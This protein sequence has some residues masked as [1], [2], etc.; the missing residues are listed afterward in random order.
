[1]RIDVVVGS[2]YGDEGKGKVVN[3]LNEYFNYDYVFRVNASTNASH[4]VTNNENVYI[5]KQLPSIFFKK[6]TKLIVSPGA[7]LNLS[8]LKEE[9]FNRPDIEEIKDNI[10]IASSI[11]LII[12]PFIHKNKNCEY[13]KKIGST[14]QGTGVAMVTRV[15]RCDIKL[16]DVENAARDKSKIENLEEK[17]RIAC[18]NLKI[19][20][21][22]CSINKISIDLINDFIEI[23][24]K[25]GKF[26]YDYTQFLYDLI[27]KDKKQLQHILI[28]GCNG[29]L[30]DN[31]H[32]VY[33]Y[34]TSCSTSIS[35]LLN[36][37]NLSP[38]DL[39]NIF[40]VM[41]AYTCCLN[42]RPFVTEM[43]S[44]DASKIYNN[45]PEV[46]YAE[47]MKR[48]VGWLDLVVLKKALLGHI[49]CNLFINKLDVLQDFEELKICYAYK[50]KDGRIINILPDDISLIDG[51][52]PL[53]K[54]FKGFGKIKYSNNTPIKTKEINDYVNFILDELNNDN[55]S[56]DVYKLGFGP[57]S[58]NLI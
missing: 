56:C 25:V 42:K 26:C 31:L 53:Y 32:G 46:D 20:V 9:I 35:S 21:D 45:N 47:G 19:D 27:K 17:I 49:S 3:Y 23:E 15:T 39:S 30:L 44:E 43:N 10:K 11:P 50:L 52:K 38:F 14:N 48:R 51:A 28:E 33:P 58:N 40:V 6:D 2:Q 24:K 36:S 55:I 57:D 13:R 1:M 8:K 18:N 5:T 41:G 54:T 4:C 7:I 29:I 12:D 16:F 34:T 37:A 22:E